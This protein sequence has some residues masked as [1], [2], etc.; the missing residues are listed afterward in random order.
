MRKGIAMYPGT[1]EMA[2]RVRYEAFVVEGQREQS[3][4]LNCVVP[5]SAWQL[6]AR[7]RQLVGVVLMNAGKLVRRAH[8]VARKRPRRVATA[9][10]GVV[11]SGAALS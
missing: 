8:L 4:A 7:V 6:P 5:A 10:R 3:N 2:A 9:E 11:A 1:I